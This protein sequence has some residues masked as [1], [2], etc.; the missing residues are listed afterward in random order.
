MHVDKQPCSTCPYR[1]DVPSGVWA[2]EEYEKL[3]NYDEG[4]F[5]PALGIFL[6]HHSQ[7]SGRET[8][9]RGWLS[10]ASESVAVRLAMAQGTF[11]DEQVYAEVGVG[12][13]PSGNAAADF[14]QRDIEAPGEDA[15][16]AIQRLIRKKTRTLFEPRER[17]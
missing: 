7:F 4:A 17:A 9:C 2:A 5:P 13:H 15:D 1:T 6:C 8:A 16:E 14:G 11:T 3:R 12:L 10:V